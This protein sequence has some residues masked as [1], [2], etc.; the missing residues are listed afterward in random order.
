MPRVCPT[1]GTSYDEK[2]VFCPADGSSLRTID[3]GGELIG[4][5]IADRYL[6]TEQL[7]EG[8]MGRVY[9]AQHVRLPQRAAIKVLHPALLHDPDALARFNR[10][11]SNA[12]QINHQ[13]VARVYDFG[14]GGPGLV[15]LAMEYVPGRTL[16]AL[17][18][19]AG[20]LAPQRAAML[21]R[22]IASGL[23]AAH[24]LGIVHRDLK[25]DNILVV[26]DDDGSEQVKVVDFGIAKA[27]DSRTQGVTRTGLVV[28]TA[29]YM[30]PEQVSGHVIDRRSDVYALGL[31]AFVLLTGK[32]PFP[33]DTAE[34]A[35]IRRLTERPQ[36]LAEAA[37][38]TAWPAGVQAVMDRA[39]AREIADRF[40]SASEFAAALTAAVNEW[41]APAA[42]PATTT[43]G[44]ADAGTTRT[45]TR[46]AATRWRRL[47]IGGGAGVL[48]LAAIVVM[49][50]STGGGGP[51][52]V[53]V[54]GSDSTSDRAQA[55][56][57]SGSPDGGRQTA[58]RSDSAA[59]AIVTPP[60]G[61]QPGGTAERR[62]V[63]TPPRTTTSTPQPATNPA[64]AAE[65]I[66]LAR[67]DTVITV[68]HPDVIT[69]AGARRALASIGLLLPSLRTAHDSVRAELNRANAYFFLQ[70]IP[71][72]C[73]TLRSARSLANPE[74]RLDIDVQLGALGCD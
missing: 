67:L 69:E 14:E 16:S 11:A 44:R 45:T 56:G 62:G 30:S 1:C 52:V 3:D 37:P 7:G 12:C 73:R 54:G 50:L 64:V 43:T 60:A 68:L 8:G 22:Q 70:Q 18:E 61:T 53:P 29:L 40:P 9:L 36:T 41:Q 51:S 21:L 10:E 66:A 72:A 32:L 38:E 24:K 5:V 25:P 33:G 17:L 74:T 28:G 63:E 55:E 27:M 46:P 48:A 31:V 6:I 20:P 58:T 39:L 23:D 49:A 26:R 35:M 19:A 2:N 15:Y 59:G 65:R 13:H 71:D 42:A 34:E 4:S 57:E 47:A